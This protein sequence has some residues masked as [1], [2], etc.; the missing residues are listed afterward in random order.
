MARAQA[1]MKKQQQNNMT[2]PYKGITFADPPPGSKLHDPHLH[3]LYYHTCNLKS[4]IC[5]TA[6]ILLP[7][8]GFHA[9]ML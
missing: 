1:K 7:K 5:M 8:I 2:F 4:T 9:C 6:T 3:I